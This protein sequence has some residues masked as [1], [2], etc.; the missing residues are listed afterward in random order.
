MSGAYRGKSGSWLCHKKAEDTFCFFEGGG[1]GLSLGEG[2]GSEQH[3]L[4]KINFC[5]HKSRVRSVQRI[6]GWIGLH[7]RMSMSPQISIS[8]KNFRGKEKGS[9]SHTPQVISGHSGRPSFLSTRHTRVTV[10]VHLKAFAPVGVPL[11]V[12]HAPLGPPQN[13]PYITIQHTD[14]SR[15]RAPLSSL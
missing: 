11:A 15:E 14:P 9:T 6:H 10:G 12:L 2:D 3:S 7:A 8:S 1:G 13:G 5:R 4:A